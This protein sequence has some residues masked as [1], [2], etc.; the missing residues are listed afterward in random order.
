M[1]IYEY[2]C[3]ACGHEFELFQKITDSPKRKCPHCG[4]LK[5]RR[6]VSQTS[7]V[8]KGGGWYAKEYGNLREPKARGKTSSKSEGASK[9]T[10]AKG[11]KGS[12]STRGQGKGRGRERKAA[13][14]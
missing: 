7:F 2:R 5:A 6:I 1:P 9:E 11:D 8:L 4:R 13:G 14:A 12:D 10:N 3:N